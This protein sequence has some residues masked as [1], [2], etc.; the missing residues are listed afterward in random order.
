ME[1]TL[2]RTWAEVDLDA[3]EN[4]YRRIRKHIGE[5]VKFLGVVKADA[6]GHGAIQVSKL[7]EKLG[8]DYLAVSS[9]DE[10]LELRLNEVKLP[11][12]ILGHTPKEQVD[13]LIEFDI[14][15]A[16]TCK[17]KAIEYSEEAKRLGGTLK[18]HIKVDTGM[19]RL[20]YLCSG[21]NFFT[22]VDG[23]VEA[24]NMP[25]LDAEGIFTHFAV[26]DEPGEEC[27]NYTKK[28]F[29]L[30]NDV[31]NKVEEKLGRKF[32]L[33][34]CA[35]TGAV[36]CYPKEYF[37]DMVRPGL[38]LYGYGEFAKK[39]G[40]EPV[41]SFKTTISTIKVYPKG[42]AISYGGIFKTEKTTRIGVL[43]CGYADGFFRSLS[44]KCSLVTKE[45]PAKQRGKICM[46]MCMIDITDMP[47]VDVGSEVE[48]Y[49]RKN[50]IEDLAE[51]AQTIPYELTC[52]VS[53]RVPRAYFKNH[54]EIDRELMLRI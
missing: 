34:H 29:E 43:P 7:L 8:A 31:I 51:L 35:N 12:L 23:I 21:D 4:N 45:G 41:M 37:M 47:S 5:N 19:S 49:G 11:I 24:C 14:T 44:N 3:L 16:V 20:G 52:A 27:E 17:A 6:Y 54:K 36:A 53:K 10:A 26:S 28:Q 46:D 32:R 39:M 13:R 50:P 38:L 33:K 2:R 1:S 42:T 25:G 15:Q 30:F 22:G 18:V 9:I 48:I 40:L